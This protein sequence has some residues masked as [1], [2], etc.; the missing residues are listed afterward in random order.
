MSKKFDRKK[1]RDELY[2]K[3]QEEKEQD[4]FKDFEGPRS[5]LYLLKF[6]HFMSKYRKNIVI[7]ILGFFLVIIF[8][9]SF[10]EV[11]RH[12]ENSATLAIE[13]L[14]LKLEKESTLDINNKIQMYEKFRS[15][16]SVASADLRSAKTLSDLL[17]EKGEFKK[18][19]ELL[20][21]ASTSI[22]QPVELKAFYLYIAASHRESAGD[23]KVA[24]QNYNTVVQLIGK[25]REMPVFQA[26][27]LYQ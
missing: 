10:F 24:Q 16:Y 15:E 11:Q 9:L 6:S 8:I 20:E 5:E 7:G 14:E 27:S 19:A 21:K 1:H 26:W 18:A 3:H 17:A 4:P 22:N 13:E 23:T 12:R 2:Y 25:N